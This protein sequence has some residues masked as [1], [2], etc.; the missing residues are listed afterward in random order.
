MAKAIRH[1]ICTDTMGQPVERAQREDGVW[2]ARHTIPNGQFG[3]RICAWYKMDAEPEFHTHETNAYSG[4]TVEVE[5]Y[6]CWGFQKMHEL[7]ATPLRL[8]LPNP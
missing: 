7:T 3:N 1:F 6:M 2:F 5:P 4:E 8:R